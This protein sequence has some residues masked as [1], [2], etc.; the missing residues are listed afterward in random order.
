MEIHVAKSA[1]FCFGV[2]R[3]V[4]MA[5]ESAKTEGSPVYMLG[6][7]VHN[8]HVIR[9]LREAGIRVVDSLDQVDS[10]TLLIRAHGAVPQVYE[11]ARKTGLKILD[12]TCS[13]VLEIHKIARQLQ[14]EG[15]TIV[16]IG[17]HGHDEVVG[18]AGQVESPI[19]IASPQEAAAKVDKIARIG[20]VV[21]ST[22][23]IENVQQIVSVLVKKC[24]E[25]RF[26]NTICRT[27]TN[28]Q[29]DIRALPIEN[30]I[31]LIIGSRKSANTS[32]LTEISRELNPRTY[33]VESVDEVRPEWFDG[34]NS[35]GVSA[36]ASTPDKIIHEV[37]ERIREI[38]TRPEQ[39]A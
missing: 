33:Q 39:R 18:I 15:Y 35:V 34:V 8:E 6:D 25:L 11:T 22:Q 21:Q 32:R 24:H 7:I 31:M 9:E 12:A 4:R 13:L 29:H 23:N 27:T 38:A 20:V 17:D 37:I 5:L 30:D 2:K 3:A 1:G 26:V 36:G 10:G 19:I 16:I 14:E 28:H